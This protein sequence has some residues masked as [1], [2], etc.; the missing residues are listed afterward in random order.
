MET[1]WITLP[2]NE[3]NAIREIIYLIASKNLPHLSINQFIDKLKNNQA[4]D[5]LEVLEQYYS[6]PAINNMD[7]SVMLSGVSSINS[8]FDTKNEQRQIIYPDLKNKT[9][10]PNELLGLVILCYS[11]PNLIG[12]DLRW[13]LIG[14]DSDAIKH[15]IFENI[16]FV[17]AQNNTALPFPWVVNLRLANYAVYTNDTS[18]SLPVEMV[19]RVKQEIIQKKLVIRVVDPQSGFS[20]ILNGTE[21]ASRNILLDDKLDNGSEIDVHKIF[22]SL[23]SDENATY[24][25]WMFQL[26]LSFSVSVPEARYFDSKSQLTPEVLDATHNTASKHFLNESVL[27]GG[28]ALFQIAQN[29]P[30]GTVFRNIGKDLITVG[31]QIGSFFSKIDSEPTE[32]IEQTTAPLSP[33]NKP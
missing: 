11:N 31:K 4:A 32:E 15:E 5:W 27:L 9:F 1:L 13:A 23:K 7:R 10:T 2:I 24:E 22:L 17:H 14:N 33:L 30:I 8:K 16:S 25:K 19:N 29:T 18:V 20:E 28:L 6:I 12:P 26:P 3:E 21:K